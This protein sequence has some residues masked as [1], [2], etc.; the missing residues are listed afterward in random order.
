MVWVDFGFV[1]SF[2]SKMQLEGI[3]PRPLYPE[4]EPKPEPEPEPETEQEPEPEPE[5]KPEGAP[6]AAPG[7]TGGEG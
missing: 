3:L 4:P 2:R 6:A 5:P 7:N 1:D